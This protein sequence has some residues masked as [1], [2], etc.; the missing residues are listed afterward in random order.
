MNPTNDTQKSPRMVF[1]KRGACST[2]MCHLVNREYRNESREGEDA[3]SLLAGGI[4]LKGQ[5]CGMLWG[6]S[7]AVGCEAFRRF[8]GS[9]TAVEAAVNASKKL[10]ES[11]QAQTT[12]V[13]CR[14]ITRTDWGNKWHLVVY[15]VKIL[16]QGVIFSP[17]FNLIARWTPEALQAA[18]AGLSESPVCGT[19][20]VSCASA[21]LKMMGASEQDAVAASGFSGGIGLSGHAC[22]ALS[23][24]LWYK[25]LLWCRENPGKIPSYFNNPDATHIMNVF[26]AHTGSALVCCTISGRHFTTAQEHS[27]FINEGGCRSLLHTLASL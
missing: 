17:C 9:G 11:F 22:G 10:V 27:D 21:V 23:A 18:E 3:L 7:L 12:A 16:A 24:V 26:N 13:N 14:D 20:C 5:Q 15:T 4:L 25:M 2:A 1:W 6:A 8:G 19:A